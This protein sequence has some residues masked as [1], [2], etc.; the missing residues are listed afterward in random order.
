LR[1]L[2]VI[3]L[4]AGCAE[5]A[6]NAGPTTDGPTGCDV[7]LAFEPQMVLAGPSTEVRATAIVNGAPGVNTFTWTVTRGSAT[8]TY[9]YAQ[10]DQ[11]A[12]TFIA[13]DPGPYHV[14]VSVMGTS[15]FCPTAQSDVNASVP[16]GNVAQLRLRVF[17]A[18][19]NVPMQEKLVLV[20]GG[21]PYALGTVPI[22][23]GVTANGTVQNGVQ[24]YLRFMP[25]GARDA[26]VEAFT[27]ADGS[28]T[29]RVLNA[30]HDVLVV[31]MVP[32]WA[33]RVIHAWSPGMTLLAL[34]AGTPITG[35]V[36]DPAN[37]P[38]ADA[39]VQLTL[40]GVPTTLATTDAAGAFTVLATIPSGGPEVGV[41][42]TPPETTGLPR[43]TASSTALAP[44]AA[45]TIRYASN[46]VRRDIGGTVVRRGGVAQGGVRVKI[47]GTIAS[48]ATITATGTAMANG[49]VRIV[50]ATN[51]GGAL[52][53]G[54]LAPASPLSAVSTI[55]TTFAVGAFDLTTSVPSTIDAPATVQL[56]TQLRDAAQTALPSAILELAPT[57][58]LALAGVPAIRTVANSAGNISVPVPAGGTFDVRASDPLGRAAP[59]FVGNVATQS[60]A[61]SYALGPALHVTGSLV[62]SGNP[63]PLGRA[64]VQILCTLC[65]GPERARPIG[66][67]ASTSTGAFDVAVEDPGVN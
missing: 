61:A 29:K 46:L 65:T 38:I 9:A 37:A 26:Y 54:T 16:G 23:S 35:V 2:L 47:V 55:G 48:V 41:D 12:I 59:L 39:K 63:Q 49:E 50:T 14:M 19:P 5:K 25:V 11:S 62:T 31:P 20:P 6:D 57:G 53:A 36:R 44:G 42:V 10:P 40:D 24:S 30:V 21:A 43:I 56:D 13:A 8:V 7:A 28:F 60:L 67:G 45:F 18:A 64:T 4:G 32:G 15:I 58:S 17:P 52:P 22:E 33:P 3:L 51:G 27:A 66:E 1:V 34:D